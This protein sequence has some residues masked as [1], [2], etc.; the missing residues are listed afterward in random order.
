MNLRWVR[1]RISNVS[2][3]ARTIEGR[4]FPPGFRLHSRGKVNEEYES[5]ET[6]QARN[7]SWRRFLIALHAYAFI[8]LG[9]WRTHD[10]GPDCFQALEPQ[11]K[12][13]GDGV[14]CQLAL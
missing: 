10:D 1:V 5:S 13:E 3:H 14:A 7:N 11:C 4:K 9:R 12:K 8:G 2:L 6:L